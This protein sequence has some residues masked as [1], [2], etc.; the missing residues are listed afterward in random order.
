[1]PDTILLQR[2]RG[3]LLVL[4]PHQPADELAGRCLAAIGLSD[5][6]S[7]TAGAVHHAGPPDAPSAT[8]RANYHGGTFGGAPG[9]THGETSAGESRT[10]WSESDTVLITYGDSLRE[11]GRLPLETLTRFATDHLRDSF[12]TIHL[13]PFFPYSSDDGFSVMD[14]STVNPAVGTWEHV[15]ALSDHFRIMADLVLNHCSSRSLWFANYLKGQRPG[16]GY[17]FE[18][19]PAQDTSAVVRPRT[20]PLLREVQTSQGQRWVWCTF[21]HDQIDLDFGNPEVLLEFLGIIRLYLRENIRWF[22]LDAVAFLWKRCGSSCINLPETH[23]IIRLL[24][25]LM[26]HAAPDAVIITE[27][28]IPHAENLTYFGNG[29]EAHL[30]YNFSLPPLLLHALV[31]GSCR[32]LQSCLLSMPPARKG[33]ACLNFIASHDGIGLRPAEGLLSDWE[34]DSLLDAMQRFGGKVSSRA[35]SGGGAKPYEINISLWDAL[36]GTVQKGPDT[37]QYAR[38]LCA[39]AIMLALQGIPAIYIHSLLATPNDRDR[40]LHTGHFRS[41]N[42]HIWSLPELEQVLA[43]PSHHRRI[44][45]ALRRL[46]TI[47]RAQPAFHPDAPQHALHAGETLFAV[48][49]ESQDRRQSLYAIGNV[50]DHSQPLSLAALDL[51]SAGPWTDLISGQVFPDP[52]AAVSLSPYQCL[53]LSQH[54]T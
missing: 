29:N 30:I 52:L 41:I 26:E 5:V 51:G 7:A 19:H 27:T 22:R 2:L 42:R 4:Y 20:S 23:E 32:H 11:E 36:G 46:L 8:S 10:V 35:T 44:F 40:V 39:H 25:L 17:F 45:D 18:G 31:S 15:T 14:Y 54:P 3:H 49:R 34:L 28:N 47:R 37:W 1:M 9:D 50:T 6:P 38:F 13:L 24:R 21:S 33:T 48:R 12:S 53:W 16:A 43:T